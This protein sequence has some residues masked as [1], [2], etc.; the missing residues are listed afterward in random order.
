MKFLATTCSPALQRAQR[1]RWKD[2]RRNT[3]RWGL[4][5]GIRPPHNVIYIYILKKI[6]A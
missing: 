4:E 2:K 6:S 5:S 1:H 3:Y